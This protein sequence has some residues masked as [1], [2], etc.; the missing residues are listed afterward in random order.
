[1]MSALAWLTTMTPLPAADRPDAVDSDPGGVVQTMDDS[2]RVVS[3][4][5]RNLSRRMDRMFGTTETLPDEVYDSMLRLRFIQRLDEGGGGDFEFGA[6]GVLSLPGTERRL[7]LVF[8]SDDYD[9]PVARERGT[10]REIE[11]PTRRSLA[12]RLLRPPDPWGSDISVGLRSGDPIDMLTRV[13][14]W[15]DFEVGDLWIRPGQSLF[16]YDEGGAGTATD[17]RVERPLASTRMLL[18][19][20]TRVTWF[21]REEQFYYDQVFSLLQPLAHR[22]DLLWQIGVQGESEPNDRVTRYYA[23]VRW[24][25]VLN[26]DWLIAELRPQALRERENDFRTQWR[27]YFGFELLF[28][29]PQ[30]Y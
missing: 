30:H 26:R 10:E 13:R 28:G 8:I 16:W 1:M 22:R 23:Q 12:L 14:G 11:D 2:Q 24:R 6:G 5:I 9:D 4:S 15:R 25:S 3:E 18:R 19:S 17:F 21:K 29:D 20:H 27:L 7:S